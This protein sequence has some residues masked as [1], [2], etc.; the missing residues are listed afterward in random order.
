M[1]ELYKIILLAYIGEKVVNKMNKEDEKYIKV[2]DAMNFC[3]QWI[4][5]HEVESERIYEFLDDE[6]EDDLVFYV[7]T[8]KEEKKEY[9]IIL[10]VV[11]YIAFNIIVTNKE[12]IPQFLSETD[13]AYYN[14]IIEDAI[15]LGVIDYDGQNMNRIVQYCSEKE[16]EI[17]FVKS[18]IMSL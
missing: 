12:P 3:W 9:E 17:C 7:I 18:Q 10:G 16:N 8:A 1:K 13:E 14:S 4:E 15:Q 5:N 2:R 6:E 11:S